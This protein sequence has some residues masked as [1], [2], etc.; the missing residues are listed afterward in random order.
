METERIERVSSK[1]P[2][3]LS[4]DQMRMWNENNYLLLPSY[5][6]QE[7]TNKMIDWVEEIGHWPLVAGK[8]LNY[9]EMIGGEPHISRTENFL[10]F[11][12][13]FRA[14]I[15]DSGIFEIVAEILGEPVVLFKEKINYKYPGT[16]EY[17]PHQDVHAYD[18][19]PY[20]FQPYH[21]NVTVFL[22]EATEENGCMELGWGHPKNTV[23]DRHPN[24]A[25]VEREVQRLEWRPIPCPAGSVF[26]FDMFW[27]HKSKVN[28]S[29]FP[30]RSI[31]MTFNGISRG[32]LREA[33]YKDRASN[34]PNSREIK[35]NLV[36]QT[37][38][39]SNK[40]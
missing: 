10:P 2:C 38:L 23:L 24:G 4:A 29:P 36:T 34:K 33:H 17:P 30:R 26:V 12:P 19:S 6:S 18:T 15:H 21:R 27:P 22:D 13:E 37:K 32:D 31:F 9:Y 16:G 14:L 35:S 40:V 11:H 5:F 20:A 28:R 8:Y 1:K 3:P 7:D 39:L 25:L